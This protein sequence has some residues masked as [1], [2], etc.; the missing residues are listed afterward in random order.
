MIGAEGSNP[1]L[2]VGYLIA[3]YTISNV[4]VPYHAASTHTRTYMLSWYIFNEGYHF[5]T[6][7][8][9]RINQGF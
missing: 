5:F 9:T 6:F 2:Q 8:T 7:Q 4:F 1:R 3:V